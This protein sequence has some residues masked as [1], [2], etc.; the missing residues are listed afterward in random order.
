MIGRTYAEF[1]RELS[2]AIQN[3]DSVGIQEKA[4]QDGNFRPFYPTI[5]IEADGNIPASNHAV[6]RRIIRKVRSQQASQDDA[7]P[8]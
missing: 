4:N 3:K 1:V 8:E 5:A 7:F 6:R 2:F